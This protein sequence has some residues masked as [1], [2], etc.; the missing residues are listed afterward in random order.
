MTRYHPLRSLSAVLAVGVLVVAAGC[1]DADESSTP[2]SA[3]PT[4]A[5]APATTPPETTTAPVETTIEDTTP[6]TTE[7]EVDEPI[8]VWVDNNRPA[9]FPATY[10]YFFPD[11]ITVHPG[12]VVEF[13]MEWSSGEPH[14]VALGTTVDGARE[15]IDALPPLETTISPGM[16]LPVSPELQAQFAKMPQALPPDQASTTETMRLAQPCYVEAGDPPLGEPCGP[17]QR[18]PTRPFDGTQSFISSQVMINDGDTFELQ[19]DESIAPGTYTYLCTLHPSFMYGSLNVVP[20]DE[21][22]DTAADVAERGQAAI[23]E[24]NERYRPEA[25]RLAT[26]T[27]PAVEAGGLGDGGSRPEITIN[28]F[29]NEIAAAVDEPVTWDIV[30]AH[31]L[32]FEPPEDRPLFSVLEEVDGIVR[33]LDWQPDQ[34]SPG[35]PGM[36]PIDQVFQAL[37]TQQDVVIDGGTLGPGDYLHT[38][39]LFGSLGPLPRT[40]YDLRFSQPGVYTYYCVR[41][42]GMLGTV[43][44]GAD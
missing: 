17:D 2:S 16:P 1:A 12:Q 26:Q 40:L 23:D 28:V 25:E 38:G 44:V 43:N 34:P 37:A 8:V 22:A 36:P 31:M 9:G 35:Q 29:P 11:D 6:P 41:H 19:L 18:T 21:P 13:T 39:L 32:T 24:L 10:Q 15:A 20:E 33:P 7:P 42:P 3:A 30:G 27:G 5:E 14:N 4:T